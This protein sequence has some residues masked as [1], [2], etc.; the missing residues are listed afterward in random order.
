M[1]SDFCEIPVCH[2]GEL[3]AGKMHSGGGEL[4]LGDGE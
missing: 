2:T 3:D 1:A 4:L